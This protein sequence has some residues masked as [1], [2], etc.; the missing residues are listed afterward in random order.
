VTGKTLGLIGLGKVGTLVVPRAKAFGMKVVY[1]KRTRLDPALEM[2]LGITWLPTVDNVMRASDFVSLHARFNESSH[3][4][5]GRR[6]FDLMKPTAFF[7]QTARGRV[8]DEDALIAVLRERRIAGAA[9]DVYLNE[10]PVTPSPDPDPRFFELDNVLLAPHI[11]GQTEASLIDL[12]V[13][14]A[15]NLVAM[16]KGERPPDL[17]NPEVWERRRQ[18][19]SS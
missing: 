10:P 6:E 3:Q 5:L 4:L 17:L 2:T 18:I 7:I 13:N 8:I 16:I 9:L 19:E 1:T 15:E 14:P 12:A 11:G